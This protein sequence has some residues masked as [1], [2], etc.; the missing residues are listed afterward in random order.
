MP[1]GAVDGPLNTLLVVNQRLQREL[2]G[3]ALAKRAT[4][5]AQGSPEAAGRA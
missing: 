3:A 1:A 2:G 4:G 5:G